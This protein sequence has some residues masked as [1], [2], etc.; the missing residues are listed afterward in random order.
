MRTRRV[1]KLLVANRSEIALRVMRTARLMGLGTVAVYSDADQDA[2]HVRFADEAVRLGP[3]P[4]SESYLSAAAILRAA[5]MTGADAVHP[6]YGFLA[7]RPD[8]AQA[9]LDAGLTFVGPPPS[10]MRAMA[11]KREARALAASLGLQIVPGGDGG[12]QSDAALLTQARALGL[13][14]LFKPSAGGGGKGLR[15]VRADADLLPAIEAARREGAHAFGDP[16][17]IVERLIDRPRHVEIQVLGDH[18]G[19]LVHL[20]ERECSIQRRAQ[21]II[22]ETPSLAVDGSLRARLAEAALTLARAIG[23]TNAGTVEFLLD[24]EG[25]FFF[26]EMNTRLQVEH[27]VTELVFGIDLVEL[28]LRIARGEP[29]PFAQDEL[30]Q[31]GHAVECRVYAEKPADRFLPSAGVV[32]DW[33]V[34]ALGG[35]LVDSGVE[36]RTSVPVEYDPMVAKV[37]SLGDDR[38]QAT[39][40]LARALEGTSLLGLS[41]NLGLLVRLL[42]HA[43]YDAGRIHTGFL[44]EHPELC[45]DPVEPDQDAQAAIAATLAGHQRRRRAD[46][47]LPQV[48]TGWRNNRWVDQQADYDL[49]RLEYRAL[50]TDRFLVRLGDAETQW[51]IIS[52]A[53]PELVL[54]SPQGLRQ[55]FRVVEVDGRHWVHGQGGIRLLVETPRYPAPA[56]AALE[57]GLFAPMPGK[58]VRVLVHAGDPVKKGQ[59]L[60]V[61]EAMKMEQSVVSLEEGVVKALLVREGDQV[62]SGQVLAVVGSPEEPPGHPTA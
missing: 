26:S 11:T 3:A 19:H 29:L 51:R 37:V 8:F 10:A 57:G 14:V 53:E 25:Q 6:G 31:K 42:R 2:P 36:S 46:D 9:V 58:V 62:S 54:E 18:H 4:A 5:A 48:P 44:D 59:A 60:V 32:R 15:A 45:R 56:D 40:K 33:N 28:Q 38:S 50:G 7:E 43:E 41:S 49:T 22:E 47:F 13:P 27:R 17:L 30:V 24:A 12:D 16:T 35:L 61:V 21:K 55:R 39:Q 23:Y 1:D 34:P 52:F 20:G